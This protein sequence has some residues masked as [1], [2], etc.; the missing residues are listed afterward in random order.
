MAHGSAT[1]I[2]PTPSDSTRARGSYD[3]PTFFGHLKTCG[4]RGMF[5]AESGVHGA[6]QDAIRFSADFLRK[7]WRDAQG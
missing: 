1:S 4:Y 2:S 7:A 3:Y 5:S 6:P